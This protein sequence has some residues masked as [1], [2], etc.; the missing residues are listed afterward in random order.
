L[1]LLK[2]RFRFSCLLMLCATG[3]IC[4]AAHPSDELFGIDKVWDIHLELSPSEW[5]KLQPPDDLWPGPLVF[6]QA[7]SGLMA[8]A[9]AGRNLHSD[10][11]SRPGLAGYVG[12]DHQYG[13]GTISIADQV[14]H[15]VGIRFKGNGSFLAGMFGSRFSFKIDF[16]EYD[17]DLEY[18]G[19]T[20]INLNSNITD[21]TM[22]REAISYEL[23]RDAGIE[24]SRTAWARVW[25]TVSG[26]FK[27]KDLGLFSIVEQVD[28]RFLKHRYGTGDGMLLKPSTF[29]TFRYFEDDWPAYEKAYF[30]KTRVRPEQAK[31][32]MDFARLVWRADDVEF[33]REVETYLDMEQ[34]LRFLAVN[35]LL[36]NLDSFLMGSQN[37]YVYLDPVS[38]R[39]QILPWDLDSSFGAMPLVGTAETRI[40]QSIDHPDIDNK[41]IER[42]LAIENYRTQYRDYIATYAETG[43]AQ[44]RVLGLIDKHSNFLRPIV[45]EL[46]GDYLRA[47]ND[48]LS[49]EVAP[50]AGS[51]TRIRPFVKLRYASLKAQLAGESAGEVL[52]QG[53]GAP[54]A[55]FVGI[56]AMILMVLTLLMNLIAYIRGIVVGFK[57][58]AKWG[59]LNIFYPM[60]IYFGFRVRR[61]IG[62]ASARFAVVAIIVAI[63]IPVLSG[64]L[65]AALS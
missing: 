22:L 11:S 25:L 52:A 26:E 14:L 35:V 49:E 57:D 53:R 55:M 6:L 18:L 30:P 58:S 10:K 12:I 8:D 23:F 24:A 32:L 63:T 51:I 40:R 43:M 3:Q 46:G 13:K 27:Q 7:F 5:A 16:N 36:S 42:V 28:K 34:F 4:C 9:Q 44:H 19:L 1:S 39:F 20:K 54:A 37:H 45:K 21:A 64:V 31:V 41:L 2:L 33:A 60:T 15:N 62:Y 65:M 48:A 59:C 56:T 17:E 50:Q 38:N 61:D 47:F 29:G